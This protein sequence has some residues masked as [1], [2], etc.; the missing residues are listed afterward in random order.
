MYELSVGSKVFLLGEYQ[1]LKNGTAFLV[2]MEPRFKIRVSP[3]EGEL[4]GIPMG[5]PA[6]LYSQQES[7]FFKK[8]NIEFIDPHQGRGGFGASTAQVGLLIAFKESLKSLT[9]H[10]QLDLDLKK[11]HQKYLELVRPEKGP[12]PSGADLLC[13]LQGGLVELDMPS[14]KIQKHS[15]PFSD[16]QVY[17][18]T[19]GKKLATHIHLQTLPVLN[20]ENREGR[21][22]QVK[23]WDGLTH[24]Y[25]QA[26]DAFHQHHQ[27]MFIDSF[28]EYQVQLAQQGWQSEHTQYCLGEL[29]SVSGVL[30]SKGCGAMGADVIAVLVAK[31]SNSAKFKADQDSLRMKTESLGLK[32]IGSLDQRTEGLSYQWNTTSTHTDIVL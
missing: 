2:S 9:S 30:A 20:D 24:V 21:E 3:G 13:Q 8:W 6:A 16:L 15:W 18:F 10:A 25:H 32:W 17:F 31:S 26:M 28:S 5:S 1:V 22:D 4:S 23:I 7:E 11:I 19:T 12:S 27:K 29:N 14:G